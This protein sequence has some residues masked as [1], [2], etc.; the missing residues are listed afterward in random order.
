MS[1]IRPVP[2]APGYG[3][4]P[5]GNVFSR[6]K[7]GPCGNQLQATWRPKPPY[8]RGDY[9]IVNLMVDGD[10]RAFSVHRLVFTTFHGEIPSG[11]QINHIDG[12]KHNNRP[13]NL[14]LATPKENIAHA[15][16]TGLRDSKGEAHPMTKLNQKQA[17]AIRAASCGRNQ[18]ELA[19]MFNVS[20]TTIGRVIHGRSW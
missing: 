13:E 1:E 15:I 14:E 4:S 3:I 5:D 10:R 8:Q 9:L 19:E 17:D 18:R 6:M 7:T 2:F 12:N 16:R 20:R 11:L